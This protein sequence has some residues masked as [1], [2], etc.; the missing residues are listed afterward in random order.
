MLNLFRTEESFF[1]LFEQAAA[2]ILAGSVVLAELARDLSKV[3][4]KAQKIRDIEHK[5]DDLTHEGITRLHKTFLP[6]LDREDVHDILS[7]M[8]DI[9][10]Y[11]EAVA[12]RVYLYHMTNPPG[13]FQELADILVRCSHELIAAVGLLKSRGRYREIL[14]ILRRIHE[15]ENEG[16]R[17]FRSALASLF[18]DMKDPIEII[19]W[20]EIFEYLET[21]TDRCE[22]VANVLEGVALKYA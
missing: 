9:I 4:E 13:T 8:D 22:D 2:N 17:A 14:P 1:S 18:R 20:K 10:D 21:A 19:K 5:G 11:I 6:P 16:D 3:D 15:L 12:E 7:R